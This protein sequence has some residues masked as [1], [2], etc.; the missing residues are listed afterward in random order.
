MT[1]QQMTALEARLNRMEKAITD[2]SI[3][4]NFISSRLSDVDEARNNMNISVAEM[5]LKEMA[6]MKRP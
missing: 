3:L 1:V 4:A 6:Y 2:I 5:Q